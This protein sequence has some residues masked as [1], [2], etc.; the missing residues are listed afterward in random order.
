[1]GFVWTK[2]SPARFAADIKALAGIIEDQVAP[3]VDKALTDA[4]VD[5]RATVATSGTGYVG[6]GARATAEGRID[7][8]EMYDAITSRKDG[9]TSGRFGWMNPKKYYGLQEDG[10]NGPSGRPVPPMHA[11]LG[12][13]IKARVQI[14]R[15]LRKLVR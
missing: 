7:T 2:G 10:F 4:V 5:M 12:A 15:D 11:L 14:E 1:M 6:K 3:I 8:G 13:F 9:K